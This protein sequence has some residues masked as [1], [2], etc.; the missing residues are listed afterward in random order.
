VVVAG[1]KYGQGSS[2]EHDAI[3]PRYL[4]LQAVVAKSFG[5]S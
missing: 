5:A 3:A 4:G 1:H 2:R